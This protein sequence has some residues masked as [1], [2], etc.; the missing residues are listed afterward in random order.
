[1]LVLLIGG[2]LEVRR[3]DDL[4]WDAIHTKFHNDWFRRWKVVRG[5]QT[6][7]QQDDLI[8]QISVFFFSKCVK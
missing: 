1:V 8:S 7:V 3:W 4:R 5:T 6:H 2:I